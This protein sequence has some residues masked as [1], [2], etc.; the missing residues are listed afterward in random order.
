MGSTSRVLQVAMA[1]V[2]STYFGQAALAQAAPGKAVPIKKGAPETCLNFPGGGRLGSP[3]G[4]KAFA[5]IVWTD[6]RVLNVVFKD[7]D[8]P[9][10]RSV[11]NKLKTIVKE[12]EDYADI[13]FAFEPTKPAD[14][15]I[16]FVPDAEYPE[17]GVYQSLLGPNSRRQDP[18]MW[19]QFQPGTDDSEL[20]RVIL[21]EFGH[22]C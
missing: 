19:L 22:A 2:V 17:Y 5:P 16:Q 11:Q 20:K 6:R 1:I 7:G 14:I 15:A 10:N 21:H 3:D 13:Q 9:W 4:K 18:S 8:D 12:W